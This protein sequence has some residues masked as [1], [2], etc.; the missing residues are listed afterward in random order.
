M[1]GEL[2]KISAKHVRQM[3]N[4][5]AKSYEGDITLQCAYQAPFAVLASL[6]ETFFDK[7]KRPR[8]LDLGAGTG[9][10]SKL[11]KREHPLSRITGVDLSSAM[12]ARAK[13][14]GAVNT[15]LVHDFQCKALPFRDDSFDIVVSSG[16][17]ELLHDLSLP[18]AEIERVLKLGGAFSFTTYSD[19]RQTN[20]PNALGHYDCNRHDPQYIDEELIN[21]GL[22]LNE[23]S[24]TYA[25]TWH[26]RWQSN[27]I[28]YNV[29]TGTKQAQEFKIPAP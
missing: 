9:L 22:T 27:D 4:K 5:W 13:A 8:I 16:A 6:N 15:T 26:Q 10:V 1:S 28:Y 2:Q 20:N 3:Y 17:F 24:R 14:S 23:R 29:N 7:A 18:I 12:L 19:A 21:A 11:L 25:M